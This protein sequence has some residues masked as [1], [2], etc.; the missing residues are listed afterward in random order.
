MHRFRPSWAQIYFKYLLLLIVMLVER[1]DDSG[2]LLL[3][4]RTKPTMIP[5][6]KVI[7]PT[8]GLVAS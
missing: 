1:N 8:Y 5:L 4:R 6:S 7:R 2:D 3:S